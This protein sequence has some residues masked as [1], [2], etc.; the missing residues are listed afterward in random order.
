MLQNNP[1]SMETFSILKLFNCKIYLKLIKI[2]VNRQTLLVSIKFAA[3]NGLVRMFLKSMSWNEI[4][5][6]YYFLLKE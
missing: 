4:E 5:S 6:V 2:Y 3:E 1:S